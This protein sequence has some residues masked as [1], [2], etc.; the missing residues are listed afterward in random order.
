LAGRRRLLSGRCR[1]VRRHRLPTPLPAPHAGGHR[2]PRT[3]GPHDDDA[4][5]IRALSVGW[6]SWRSS[7]ER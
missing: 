2:L 6:W 4:R 7:R 3:P 5:K 1:P